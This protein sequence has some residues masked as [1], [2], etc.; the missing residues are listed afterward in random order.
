ML[1]F[2]Y[3]VIGSNSCPISAL[4]RNCEGSSFSSD[5]VTLQD[6]W[7]ARVFYGVWFMPQRRGSF[8]VER[9]GDLF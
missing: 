4:V 3:P 7:V 5:G 9:L 1:I 2:F 6:E 8:S